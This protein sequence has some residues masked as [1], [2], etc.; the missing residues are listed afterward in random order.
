M[1]QKGFD[2]Q[3]PWLICPWTKR[4]EDLHGNFVGL[5]LGSRWP[6]K[7]IKACL[8]NFLHLFILHNTS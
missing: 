2:K 8:E 5:S 3:A 4:S 1:V 6:D 7:S